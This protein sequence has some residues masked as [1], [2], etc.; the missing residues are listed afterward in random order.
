MSRCR[1][2]LVWSSPCAKSAG[3]TI[4]AIFDEIQKASESSRGH[5]ASLAARW[6]RRHNNTGARLPS[7]LTSYR[8]PPP[9]PQ[10]LPLPTT[11]TLLRP[12]PFSGTTLRQFAVVLRR[13]QWHDVRPPTWTRNPRI[14]GSRNAI[15]DTPN[16]SSG[17]STRKS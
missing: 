2:P 12:K 4:S 17:I 7:S 8:P 16:L 15:C 1:W 5:R 6:F 14:T 10:K 3:R 13:S 9:G 11:G